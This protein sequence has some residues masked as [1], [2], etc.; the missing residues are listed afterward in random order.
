M[1]R[2]PAISANSSRSAEPTVIRR[3]ESASMH[4]ACPSI[5]GWRARF[6]HSPRVGGRRALRWS[7]NHAKL[8]ANQR[9]VRNELNGHGTLASEVPDHLFARWRAGDTEAM[10]ELLPLIY[11]E[12]RQLA[13]KRNSTNNRRTWWNCATSAACRSRIPPLRSRS[14]PPRSSATGPWRARG[15]AASCARALHEP[16]PVAADQERLRRSAAPRA[17]AALR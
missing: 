15:C 14:L 1:A 13:R 6:A 9:L 4:G 17:R 16:G 11:Q 5:A 10:N 12:L 8:K 7:A 2:L 3:R